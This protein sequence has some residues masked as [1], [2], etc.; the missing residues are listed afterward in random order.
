MRKNERERGLEEKGIEKEI[1]TFV[2]RNRT[3]RDVV[4]VGPSVQLMVRNLFF[5]SRNFNWWGSFAQAQIAVVSH[6]AA[7]A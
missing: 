6:M 7:V 2:N 3:K 1:R 4:V 5:Q